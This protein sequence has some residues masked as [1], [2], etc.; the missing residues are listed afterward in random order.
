MQANCICAEIRPVVSQTRVIIIRHAHELAKPSGTARIALLA[1]PNAQI[2]EFG[3]FGDQ[4]NQDAVPQLGDLDGASLL[5][6][7]QD[8]S[9]WPTTPIK[10][11]IVLDG[12]WRQARRMRRRMPALWTLPTLDLHQPAAHQV[13][14]RT[15]TSPEGRSTLEAIAEALGILE[16]P[17]LAAPLHA[18]HNRFIEQTLRARGLWTIRQNALGPPPTLPT[19]D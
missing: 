17:A 5:F 13:R 7:G 14:L 19:D 9:V 2:V 16:G 12:T 15:P 3:Q 8:K 11:L 18:L 4:A 10:T 1:L 6:P